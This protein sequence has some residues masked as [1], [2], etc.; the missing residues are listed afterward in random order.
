MLAR[1]ALGLPTWKQP[2][3]E[4]NRRTT[5]IIDECAMVDNDK[6][7]R[8]LAHAEK[9]G[10]R[11]VLVGDQRQ[12][13]A[14]GP[15]GLFSECCHRARD[16]QKTALTEI[17]RQREAWAR[18]A[19][20]Q[21]GRGE[22]A[23]ALKAFDEHGRL[24]V[25]PT[26]DETERRLV[27]C[28][29]QVGLVNPQENL[30]LASTNSDVARLN[31]EAQ[32]ARLDAGQLGFRSVQVGEERI[33]EGDRV[34]FTETNKKLGLVKSE[35]ATV[36]HIERLTQ[37]LTVQIDGQVDRPVTFSLRTFDTLRLGYAATTHRAQ[38]MTLEQNAYVLLGGTMQNREMT[39]VQISRAK[40]ET[41]LFVDEK[42]AGRDRLE[43]LVRAA[44][45]SQE[46]L[47]SHAVAR[48][49]EQRQERQHQEQDPIQLSL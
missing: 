13:A 8:A 45:R 34:L 18:E 24:H 38:G 7:G 4:I 10:C 31:R 28:W 40:G 12:L 19:I 33:H 32:K 3:L 20:Q 9:A 49:E 27:A 42:S 30:I 2:K 16:E 1:A 39:Y 11:V 6:L 22:T 43:E 35:F 21:M 46:K 47:S 15:G 44:D 14:V 37:K 36:A 17:V 25:L 23:K 29:K 48:E 5:I 41:H 26:R